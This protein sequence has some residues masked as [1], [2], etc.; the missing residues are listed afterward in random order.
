MEKRCKK[1]EKDYDKE[2]GKKEQKEEG[3]K[4]TSLSLAPEAN[5]LDV[6][7][8]Y[9]IYCQV[10]KPQYRTS[11]KNKI[12]SNQYFSVLGQR[13]LIDQKADFK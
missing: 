5:I 9:K 11:L 13:M 3:N 2:E 1:G 7:F 12:Y 8:Q 4:Q 6:Y 10:C